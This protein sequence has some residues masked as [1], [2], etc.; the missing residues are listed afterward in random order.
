MK[1]ILSLMLCLLFCVS[2]LAGCGGLKEGEKGA[3]INVFLS[4]YPYTLDPAVPQLNHDVEQILSLIYEPL[5][6]IDE[7]GEVQPALATNWY[8]EYDEIYKEHKMYFE[9]KVTSWSDDRQVSADDVIYAWR[10]ILSPETDSP[11]ASLLYAIKGARDVK[12]GVGTIDDLGLAA[13]D[14]TLL[15]VTFE[16]E[17]DA[18]LFAE[19]VAN[20]HLAPCRED[21]VTRYQKQGKDWAASAATIVCNGKF[22]VQSMDMPRALEK[23]EE[24]VKSACRLVLERN[25]FYLREEDDDLDEYVDPYRITCYYYEGLTDYYTTGLTQQAF[26]A[27]RFNNGEIF[28]LSS[29]D[30]QTYGALKGK[31]NFQTKQTLNGYAYY[32]NTENE[33][34]KDKAVRQALSA[35]LDRNAI[36]AATG[37][38]E[39]AATGY[40]PNG[41]FNNGPET[42]FREAGG[43]LYTNG[44][45]SKKYSGTLNLI[46]LI[47]QNEH[48]IKNYQNKIDYNTG[49][50]YKIA[51]EQA[52]A[53]WEALG[54]TV[55]CSGLTPDKYLEAL[56]NRTY[57]IIGVNIV[58][59]STDAFAYLAPFAKEYSG[60]G[61]N[62][63]EL[64][65]STLVDEEVFKKHYTNYD[66]AAYSE[67]ITKALN[68]K[69]RSERANIL[70][71]AE[72]MLV[73]DC[74][75]TMA[76]WYSYSFIASDKIDDYEV[77]NYFG[78]IDFT[79]LTLD[80]W[81]EV[82]SKEE[83]ILAGRE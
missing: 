72:Q 69:D 68:T 79:E 77:N 29:F 55:K 58:N 27:N 16:N 56:Q 24:K 65:A 17:Y 50:I 23:G 82:N 33:I 80:D 53:Q 14:D 38:G 52:K 47:P 36:V 67:L 31:E 49:N 62:A 8:Y 81:R 61:L 22:R 48:T 66:N 37:T 71:Q 19:Q 26:Q 59:S 74:P 1:K 45:I 20:I 83:S 15:A 5:T 2:A 64:E 12:S 54:F 63:E 43:A 39:V 40:V 10:R 30:K 32:F 35:A 25:S 9:L 70:H 21:I 78:F 60:A 13:E 73:D 44:S 3:N 28:F 7:E 34:L 6:T 11:Y 41:V 18:D 76:F 51:A 57:D 46:Y 75:A 42:N 4:G